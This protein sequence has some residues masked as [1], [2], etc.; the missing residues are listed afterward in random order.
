METFPEF[1]IASLVVAFENFLDNKGRNL[2]INDESRQSFDL[3]EGLA[4]IAA[5]MIA[6]ERNTPV[7]EIK[8]SLQ[9]MARLKVPSDTDPA[10]FK[11]VLDILDPTY[12]TG[13]GRWPDEI[14]DIIENQAMKYGA[15]IKDI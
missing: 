7:A 5:N 8:E 3:I 15:L 11:Q 10:A 2:V 12:L 13:I 9:E 4:D 6:D 1:Y 14:I